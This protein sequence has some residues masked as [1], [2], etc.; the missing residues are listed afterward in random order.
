MTSPMS[1]QIAALCAM[2]T[3]FEPAMRE[4]GLEILRL[5]EPE[6]LRGA[7]DGAPLDGLMLPAGTDL[8]AAELDGASMRRALLSGVRLPGAPRSLTRVREA[9]CLRRRSCNGPPRSAG[10][11]FVLDVPA[12][13]TGTSLSRVCPGSA[14]TGVR[15]DPAAASGGGTRSPSPASP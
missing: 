15:S 3:H 8:S 7:F 13:A 4:Q 9:G 11:A 12:G 6:R 10:P 5:T 14:I 2:L 1:D